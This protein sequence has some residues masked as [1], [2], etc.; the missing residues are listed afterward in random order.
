MARRIRKTRKEEQRE[1]EAPEIVEQ[2]LWSLS[3]WM[4]KHWRPVLA[5]LVGVSVLWGAVGIWQ[6]VSAS[7]DQ[8]RADSTAAIFEQ[9]AMPVIPPVEKKA[10]EDP[11]AAAEAE[12]QKADAP[13]SF[14]TD[15]ARAD[16]V[17][18]AATPEAKKEPLV[19][20][21]VAGSQAVKG[22]FA[23]QLAAVDAALAQVTGQ[24][25]ELP[26]RIQRATALS[27]LGRTA[28]AVAE[29][30]KV[31]AMDPTA[32]GKALAQVRQGDLYNPHLQAKAADAGKAKTSYEAALKAA[33]TG[34]KDPA[35]GP[36]AFLV[37][38]VRQKL[39][40]L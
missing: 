24:A 39:A 19:A 1:L 35:S 30:T 18:K 20:V 38:D 17:L 34:D 22:D 16:A 15:E 9:A 28:D 14:A 12:K 26:L 8:N 2:K 3:A 21:L 36:L 37:A 7:R 6:I 32:F 23:G 13:P 33:R 10:D 27:A 4:E 31:Q 29:W 5:G 11:T 40:R 25:L